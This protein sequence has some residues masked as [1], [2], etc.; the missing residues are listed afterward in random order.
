[1]ISNKIIFGMCLAFCAYCASAAYQYNPVYESAFDKNGGYFTFD[2]NTSLVMDVWVHHT[3]TNPVFRVVDFGYYNIGDNKLFSNKNGVIGSFNENDKIGIWIK[4]HKGEIF[5]S[6]YV[7]GLTF[8]SADS[9][10]NGEFSIY[11]GDDTNHNIP[12]HYDYK[13]SGQPL[14]GVLATVIAGGVVSAGLAAKRKRKNS[15]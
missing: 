7:P 10:G 1:M 9:N 6:T 3:G 14:P 13:L 15:L 11:T 4:N 5:T 8:G 12:S 2:S